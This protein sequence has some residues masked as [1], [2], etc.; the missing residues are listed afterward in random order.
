M[1]RLYTNEKGAN[2]VKENIFDNIR[3]EI[4]RKR[5]TI[6]EFCEKLGIQRTRFYRWEDAGDFPISYLVKMSEIL[7]VSPDNILGIVSK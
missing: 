4:K 7:E 6:D 2:I 3:A 1:F 5:M